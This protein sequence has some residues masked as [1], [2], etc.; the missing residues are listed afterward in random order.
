MC[1]L[2]QQVTCILEIYIY[3]YVYI[4]IQGVLVLRVFGLRGFRFTCLGKTINKKNKKL[5]FTTHSR[6][7][8][9]LAALKCKLFDLRRVI[10]LYT[11]FGHAQAKF[12]VYTAL[13]GT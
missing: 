1:Y 4:Y 10:H 13:S 7:Y 5:R 3:I 2:N 12:S 8:V 9:V 11:I 6:I